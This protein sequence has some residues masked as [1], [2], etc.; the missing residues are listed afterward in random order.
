MTVLI[1]QTFD[2]DNDSFADNLGLAKMGG[3][4]DPES[5]CNIIQN[6]GLSMAF[7]IAHEIAHGLNAD[8]V[9]ENCIDDSIMNTE[10]KYSKE[11]IN[12]SRCSRELILNFLE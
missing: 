2:R 7:T 9:D 8:H 10:V 11:Q 6:T 4:C 1:R 3:I 5:N 12:W